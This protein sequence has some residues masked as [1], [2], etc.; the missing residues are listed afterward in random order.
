MNPDISRQTFREDSRYSRVVFQ[1]GRP[2]LDSDLNEQ[3][4]LLA[5]QTRNLAR[6]IFGDACAVDE[7]AFEI[8]PHPERPLN[9]NLED[10]GIDFAIGRGRFYANGILC[11]N[12]ERDRYSNM[13]DH[14]ET[15]PKVVAAGWW[16]VYLEAWETTVTAVMEAPLFHPA[17]GGIDTS[18]RD[19]VT[20][21]VRVF[22]PRDVN[23]IVAP[24]KQPPPKPQDTYD[25][26]KDVLKQHESAS[27]GTASF[28]V[29]PSSRTPENS[30]YRVEVH[31]VPLGSKVALVK[32]S[33]SNASTTFGVRNVSVDGKVMKFEVPPDVL[34][35]PAFPQRDGWVELSTLHDLEKRNPGKLGT[36][37]QIMPEGKCE[38]TSDE[39]A[40]SVGLKIDK[41][42]LRPW[43]GVDNEVKFDSKNW[44]SLSD[45]LE[46][47]LH[48]DNVKGDFWLVPVGVR[49]ETTTPRVP[50]GP[51]YVRVPIGM[52]QLTGTGAQ[53]QIVDIRSLRQKLVVDQVRRW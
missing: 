20:F 6:A 14:G 23:A 48:S 45:E 15:V 9:R 31:H 43:D 51:A 42:Y 49:Q 12:V 10:N 21:R 36:M 19:K 4:D 50:D 38:M 41:A 30:V 16:M 35:D 1:Q 8:S 34:R 52:I 44:H 32:T 26:L 53:Q 39:L 24:N 27:R 28:R 37:S 2:L 13:F 17:L 46:V 29:T 40:E 5:L 7:K 33:V 47:Q 3:G 25:G 18:A 11:N 22:K